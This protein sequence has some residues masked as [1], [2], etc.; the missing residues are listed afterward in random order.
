MKLEKVELG[1]IKGNMLGEQVIDIFQ[2]FDEAF[3]LFTESKYN[4]LDSSDPVRFTKSKYNP[5]D[6]SDPVRFTESKYNPLDSSDPVRFTE[7]ST[8]W[9]LQIR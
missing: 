2:E 9:T 5:L 3:K 7:S 8:L 1:G 4:P 6:S